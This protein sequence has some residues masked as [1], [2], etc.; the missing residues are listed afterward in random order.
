MNAFRD[1]A[2]CEAMATDDSSK[3]DED[4]KRRLIQQFHFDASR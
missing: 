1:G 4:A 2:M 3:T